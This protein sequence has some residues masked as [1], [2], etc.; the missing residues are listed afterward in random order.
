MLSQMEYYKR[1]T[2]L[3]IIGGRTLA[4]EITGDISRAVVR[5]DFLDTRGGTKSV[6]YNKAVTIMVNVKRK[7]G[8]LIKAI[9]SFNALMLECG[10]QYP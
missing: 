10:L 5:N 1:D 9:M 8:K 6:S 7:K 4:A 3:A 2:A